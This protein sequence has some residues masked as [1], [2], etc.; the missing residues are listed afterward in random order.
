VE[1]AGDFINEMSSKIEFEVKCATGAA[2]EGK[3]EP[4]ASSARPRS[5]GGKRSP[6]PKAPAE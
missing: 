2:A 3:D 5:G 4:K 6:K 1:K